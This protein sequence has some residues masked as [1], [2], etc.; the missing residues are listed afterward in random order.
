MCQIGPAAAGWQTLGM[1]LFVQMMGGGRL[2]FLRASNELAL[3]VEL[4]RYQV[5]RNHWND[6]T[7]NGKTQ[8]FAV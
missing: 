7:M 1:R 3:P 8:P 4:Y 2:N 5:T 6:Q